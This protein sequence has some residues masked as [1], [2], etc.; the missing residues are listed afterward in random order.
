M[1]ANNYNPKLKNYA[2][3]H[4]IE[5]TKGEAIL[6][7]NVLKNKKT[8]YT[9]NRQ[10][11]INN[12]IVDFICRKLNIIIEIDGSSHFGIEKSEY[13]YKREQELHKL[14]FTVMRFSEREVLK[15]TEVV[16]SKI[17]DVIYSIENR[18]IE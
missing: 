7:K 5:G 9:F 15:E 18:N 12:Y 14:G 13:D 8:G 6:W 16:L 10:F 11:P 1:K 2:R 17:M 4:R 3:N